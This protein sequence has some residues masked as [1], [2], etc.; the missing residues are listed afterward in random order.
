[1]SAEVISSKKRKYVEGDLPMPTQS[2]VRSQLSLWTIDQYS[3]VLSLLG[4]QFPDVLA[5]IQAENDKDPKLRKLFVRNLSFETTSESLEKVFSEFGAVQEAVVIM[6]KQAQRSK[7]FGFVTFE[8]ADDAARAVAGSS[9]EIDGRTAYVNLAAKRG[10]NGPNRPGSITSA[11]PVDSNDT[12]RTKLFVRQLD[13][14]TTSETLNQVFGE[15]GT[16]KEAVVLE[17]KGTGA[18]K[19]YGFVTFTTVEAANAALAEQSKVIDGRTTFCKLASE[20]QQNRTPKFGGGGGG[21]GQG[22]SSFPAPSYGNMGGGY[23]GMGGGGMGGGGYG[24]M[25]RNTGYG[26]PRQS[27]PQQ[28]SYGQSSGYGQ[29]PQYNQ[30][31]YNQPQYGQSY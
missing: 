31:Q 30:P 6:N 29:Q 12:S 20:G 24:G 7:G 11:I 26:Q 15:F 23:G 25:Q 5:H 2:E 14:K 18:S 16:V 1:M 22:M 27:A 21:Y 9:V 28:S 3:N 13:Y 4:S 17:D 8:T 19:G 10:D